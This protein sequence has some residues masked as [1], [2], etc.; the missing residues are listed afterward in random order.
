MLEQGQH[1]V[2]HH[3]V[4]KLV[5][6]AHRERVLS[7]LMSRTSN[8]KLMVM[9]IEKTAASSLLLHHNLVMLS[10]EEKMLDYLR[11]AAMVAL[12]ALQQSPFIRQI[13]REM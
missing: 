13:S 9:G 10:E 7:G 11:N 5:D 1:T 3:S 6:K 12:K 4:Q 8:E 2:S